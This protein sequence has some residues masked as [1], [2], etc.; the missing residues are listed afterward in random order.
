MALTLVGAAVAFLGCAAWVAC[1]AA[2]AGAG[3]SVVAGAVAVAFSS[4]AGSAIFVLG[5]AGISVAAAGAVSVAVGD[6]ASGLCAG[7]SF[8]GSAGSE[9]LASSCTTCGLGSSQAVNK[10]VEQAINK[11]RIDFFMF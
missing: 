10:N 1:A 5:C 3:S 9:A 7:I 4:G 2:F 8:V 6:V 11:A